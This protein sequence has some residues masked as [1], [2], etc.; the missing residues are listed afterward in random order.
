MLEEFLDKKIMVTRQ[1]ERPRSTNKVS[2]AFE[3]FDSIN[4][5]KNKPIKEG[6]WELEVANANR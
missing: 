3:S 6:K 1:E 5:P 2:I 4:V